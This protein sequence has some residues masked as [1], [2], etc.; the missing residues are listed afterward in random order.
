MKQEFILFFVLLLFG[1][2]GFVSCNDDTDAEI[3]P[4]VATRFVDNGD[5]S[6]DTCLGCG[7]VDI[8]IPPV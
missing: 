1:M 6:I 3:E 7:G 8:C 4:G 5:N 2:I